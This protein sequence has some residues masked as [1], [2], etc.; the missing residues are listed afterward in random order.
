M[1]IGK[2]AASRATHANYATTNGQAVCHPVNDSTWR[3]P[4]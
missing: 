2:T 4:I 1:E 3:K